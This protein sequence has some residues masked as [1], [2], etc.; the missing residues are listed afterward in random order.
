MLEE[1]PRPFPRPDFLIFKGIRGLVPA[2]WPSQEDQQS[3]VS[4]AWRC[5][6]ANSL[7]RLVAGDNFMSISQRHLSPFSLES[8]TW[9]LAVLGTCPLGR[10]CEKE[11]P[12]Q[13]IQCFAVSFPVYSRPPQLLARHVCQLFG[14][15]QGGVSQTATWEGRTG[16][17]GR[18]GFGV[19]WAWD[20]LLTVVALKQGIKLL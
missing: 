10:F 8:P 5:P 9:I 1:N 6:T 3:L 19:P 7:A 15:G 14:C 18:G 12:E 16:R 2:G 17:A 11:G 20:P 13:K 4:K